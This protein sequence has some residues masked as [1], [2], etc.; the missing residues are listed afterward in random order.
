MH[1]TKP[2][3]SSGLGKALEKKISFLEKQGTDGDNIL[4][5]K[6]KFKQKKISFTSIFPYFL[7]CLMIF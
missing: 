3:I 4:R 6:S 1:L 7:F 5:N 2:C